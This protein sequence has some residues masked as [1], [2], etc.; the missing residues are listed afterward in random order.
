VT[1]TTNPPTSSNA[2]VRVARGYEAALEVP[3][4]SKTERDSMERQLAAVR[5]ILGWAPRP[6][7]AFA[8]GGHS[9]VHVFA[10]ECD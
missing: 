2:W 4:L 6:R 8:A 3:G 7:Q 5:E 1:A 9:D 10:E